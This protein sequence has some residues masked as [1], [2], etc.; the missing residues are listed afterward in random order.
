MSPRFAEVVLSSEFTPKI[1]AVVTEVGLAFE[2]LSKDDSEACRRAYEALVGF[3]GRL[4]VVASIDRLLGQLALALGE[5]PE[6]L[7]HFED[8][9]SFCDTAG[10]R[11]EY[12]WTCWAMLPH[13]TKRDS[14]ETGAGLKNSW[15]KP[16]TSP[17]ISVCLHCDQ[18]W[19]L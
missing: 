18:E 17:L 4:I 8:A 10:Y 19:I 14:K 13:C 12:A 6:A 2:A 11:P 1:Y 15:R 16:E 5:L 7:D 3:K 9:L